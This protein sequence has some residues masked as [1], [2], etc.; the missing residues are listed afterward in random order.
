M[1]FTLWLHSKILNNFGQAF[2]TTIA[3]K[4][5]KENKNV[6]S[7]AIKPKSQEGTNSFN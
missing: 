5:P 1:D 4:Q 7:A 2:Y 6:Q 3:I